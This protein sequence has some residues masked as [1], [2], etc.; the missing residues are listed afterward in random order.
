M[1]VVLIT[2]KIKCIVALTY[3]Q[4]ASDLVLAQRQERDTLNAESKANDVISDPV[5]SNEVP[6]SDY[7]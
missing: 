1:D 5:L 3:Q 6:H 7:T 2:C 4:D